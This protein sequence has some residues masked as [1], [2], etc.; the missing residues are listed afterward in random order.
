MPHKD[1]HPEAGKVFK[2]DLGTDL[3]AIQDRCLQGKL[4]RIEDWADRLELSSLN[5]RQI[6]V[7]LEFFVHRCVPDHPLQFDLKPSDVD[8]RDLVY[9]TVLAPPHPDGFVERTI[10]RRTELTSVV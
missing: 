4:L 9:G 3:Q 2:I 8:L 6:S 1:T 7:M 10:L 5:E